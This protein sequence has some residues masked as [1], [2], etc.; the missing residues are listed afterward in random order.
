MGG[1]MKY[2]VIKSG[3]RYVEMVV[4]IVQCESIF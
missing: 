4:C 1:T 2:V 3:E